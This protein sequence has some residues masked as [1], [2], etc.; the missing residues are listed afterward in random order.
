MTVRTVQLGSEAEKAGIS[1][2]MRLVSLKLPACP[3]FGAVSGALDYAA[4]LV[5]RSP[6]IP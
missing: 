2:G 3:N 1:V 6:P 5:R 4:M